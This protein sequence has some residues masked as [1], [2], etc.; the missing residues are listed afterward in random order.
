VARKEMSGLVKRGGVWYVNKRFRGQRIRESTGSSDL[1]EA[2]RYLVHRLEQ[3]RQAE[4]CGVRPKRTWRQA[5]TKYLVEATKTSIS[6][7]ADLLEILDRFIGDIP[8]EGIHMG[9]LQPYIEDRRKAGWKKR[10]VNYG[11]QVARRILNL[12]AGEWMDEY[13]LSWLAHAPKIKL[14]REDDKTEPYPLSWDE[15]QKLFTALPAHL[16]RMALFKVNTGCRDQEVCNLRWEWEVPVPELET[17]VFLIP[18]ERVKNRQ[19]RLVVLN[20][21][22]QQVIEEVRGIHPVYVFTYRGK[23]LKRMNDRTWQKVRKE[24]GLPHVRV[25]DLKHTF[26]RRLRA[27]GVSLEDRQDL[28]GHKS[29]RITTHYSHPELEN[30]IA[31]ANKVCSQPGHKMAPMVILKKRRHLVAV[32]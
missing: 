20:K 8:L 23:P 15:Q 11:L 32:A 7:D 21:I 27:A 17:S 29:G 4:I 30:L 2:E 28:L 19:D 25:H 6:R 10:T 22:A 31:A 18:S 13:G 3:I 14:L 12:A 24:V 5:A 26:G 9:A 16:T 1:A